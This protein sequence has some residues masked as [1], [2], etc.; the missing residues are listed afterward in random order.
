VRSTPPGTVDANGAARVSIMEGLGPTH[1]LALW[2]SDQETSRC[3]M[4][5]EFGRLRTGLMGVTVSH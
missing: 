5:K 2:T 3:E 1:N 4:P